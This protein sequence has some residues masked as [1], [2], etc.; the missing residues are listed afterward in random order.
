MQLSELIQRLSK[1]HG[2][3]GD[4]PVAD[5]IEY[6]ISEVTYKPHGEWIDAP[7]IEIE[8]NMELD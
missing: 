1:L 8:S 6:P 7:F 4:L 2:I 5:I 3:H